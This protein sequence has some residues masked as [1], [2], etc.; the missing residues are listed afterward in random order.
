LVWTRIRWWWATLLALALV[1]ACTPASPPGITPG[2]TLPGPGQNPSASP[3]V[4]RP[5]PV[6]VGA[7][8]SADPAIHVFLWG[9]TS[10]ERD[11]TLAREAGFTWVKQRFEWRNIEGK[12]KGQFDWSEPDRLLPLIAGQ[13][14]R[15]I[16]RVDNQPQWASSTVQW[17]G[18]GP[19]DKLSD[20]TDYLQA[21]ATR[22]KGRIQAYEIW[23]EP[24]LSREWGGKRPDPQAYV[25]LLKA[26]YATIK[27]ADPQAIVVSAGLAPT[28]DTGTA[29][30]DVEFV[31]AMYQNG[32]KGNYDALGVNA[33]GYKADPCADPAQVAQDPNLTNNDPSPVEARRIYAFRHVEDVRDVMV[34]QGESDKQ[35]AIMEMGWTTDQR[36]NSPYTWHGVSREQQA[37][38]LV[39][40]FQCARQRW[41][42]WM[43]FMSVIYIADPT[44][45]QQQE[46]Y[47]WAITNPDGSPRPA[48][49]ALKDL[50][51]SR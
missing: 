36:P 16:A 19:P 37:Q 2:A 43:G 13:G 4:S 20:W 40:A 11:L 33:P 42:P 15:V 39:G 12:G 47:Y 45:G 1:A 35:M 7:I 23:N 46:Q 17:P 48:Y 27:A 21:L 26:S 30:P 38:F 18:S 29:I 22:Y 28:T 5:S 31:R 51:T 41:A 14:L 10:A 8:P 9:S 34:A 49:T 44:W 50:F 32:L 6:A 3:I 24:N 25:E